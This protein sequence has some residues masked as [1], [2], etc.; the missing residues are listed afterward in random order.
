MRSSETLLELYRNQ[1]FKAVVTLTALT[2]TRAQS[3][4]NHSQKSMSWDRAARR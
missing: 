4:Q 3:V 2:A 1:Q